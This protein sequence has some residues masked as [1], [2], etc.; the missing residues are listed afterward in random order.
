MGYFEQGSEYRL[1][2]GLSPWFHAFLLGFSPFITSLLQTR[3][4]TIVSHF[5]VF[6][7]T[8][9]A[10]LLYGKYL[11]ISP[12]GKAQ[13]STGKVVNMMSN[14]TTQLQRFLQFSG[15]MMVAPLQIILSLILIYSQVGNAMW[16]GVAYMG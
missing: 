2:L 10:T 13:T 5:G 7:R 11:S 3:H 1:F 12:T 4:T 6:A 15:L 16:V 14:D 9:C 8:G